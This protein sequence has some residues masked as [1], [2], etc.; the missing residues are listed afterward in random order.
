M[1]RWPT[2]VAVLLLA[3]GWA[4][5]AGAAAPN[6]AFI[7]GYATAILEREFGL[8]PRSLRVENGVITLERTAKR[9]TGTPISHSAPAFRSTACS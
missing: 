8:V 2:A 3:L 7:E 1:R 4:M 5:P 9:T 6:D